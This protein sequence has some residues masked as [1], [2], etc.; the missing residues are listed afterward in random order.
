MAGEKLIFFAI[1]FSICVHEQ[2]ELIRFRFLE[3][4]SVNCGKIAVFGNLP[5]MVVGCTG[6]AG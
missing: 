3:V 1:V 4:C 2:T 6:H 5:W